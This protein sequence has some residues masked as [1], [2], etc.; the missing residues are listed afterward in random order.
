MD[1]DPDPDQALG[2]PASGSNDAL[3]SSLETAQFHAFHREPLIV[4]RY[5]NFKVTPL[6]V[7]STSQSQSL[8][9]TSQNSG[10]VVEFTLVGQTDNR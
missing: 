9:S 8:P 7:P 10:Q 3:A 6:A 4:I 1:P 2:G 5:P